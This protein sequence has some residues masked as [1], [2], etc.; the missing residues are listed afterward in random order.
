[1]QSFTLFI[2][3]SLLLLALLTVKAHAQKI[4]I[5]DKR[6]TRLHFKMHDEIEVRTGET[7]HSGEITGIEDSMIFVGY[8]MVKVSEINAIRYDTRK[9]GLLLLRGITG[10]LPAAGL[11]LLAIYAI[12]AVINNDYPIYSQ[13]TLILA[14]ALIVSKPLVY[15]LTYHKHKIN[16]HNRLK[17]IDISIR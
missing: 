16:E 13:N 10:P 12:N 7:W 11:A 15:W 8:D 3:L 17:V 5:F 14:G 2:R 9:K 4:L 6:N 1:M